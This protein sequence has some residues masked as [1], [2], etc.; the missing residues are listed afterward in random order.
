M[1]ISRITILRLNILLALTEG[2][3]VF[4]HYVRIASEKQAALLWGYSALRL[5]VLASIGL[6]LLFLLYC[7]FYVTKNRAWKYRIEENL[8]IIIGK[9][10]VF[11][12]L[13]L[14]ICLVYLVL[15][16]SDHQLGPLA[17]YRETSRSLLVWL[18][19]VSFQLFVSYIVV[20]GYDA[21]ALQ[22]HR[23]LLIP[24]GIALVFL[25]GTTGFI[26]MTKIGLTPDKLYWQDAGVPILIMQVFLAAIL[27]TIF[28]F[29]QIRWW[30]TVNRKSDFLIILSLWSLATVLWLSQPLRPAYNL[31][32][33][34]PPNFQNYPFGDALRYDLTAQEFML[35]QPMPADF[36]V[37]PFYSFLLVIFHLIAGQDFNG[38]IVVQ[39]VL[40]ACIPPLIYLFTK[41]LGTPLAGII[42]G[43]LIIF[44]ESN[45]IL[46]T[47]VIEVSHSRLLLSDVPTMG[48]MILLALLIVN[49][50]KQPILHKWAPFTIGGVLGLLILARGNPILLIPFI[51]FAVFLVIRKMKV[52]WMAFVISFGLGLLLIL[53]PWFWHNYQVTGRLIFQDLSSSSFV[54]DQ[55]VQ[56]YAG[57]VVNDQPGIIRYIFTDPITTIQFT[58][59]HFFHNVVHSYIFLPQSFFIE[60]VIGY[61]RRMP[62]WSG[63][64][65]G[66]LPD[67]RI[68]LPF[69][70]IVLA[71]G[72]GTGW[73][74]NRYIILVPLLLGIG[75]N[76]SV[77]IT[78]RS[79]WRF[80][81]PADWITIVFYAIGLGQ[82]ILAVYS[83]VTKNVDFYNRE[84][85]L[86]KNQFNSSA[87]RMQF[88]LSAFLI[89][90]VSLGVTQG[91][92]LFTNRFVEANEQDLMIK[93]ET[94]IPTL[95]QEF[96]EED[97]AVMLQGRGI[98][99]IYFKADDGVL[100]YSY[101]NY[102]AKPYNRL[103]FYLVNSQ[104]VGVLLKT[105]SILLGFQDGED[106]V[107]VGCKTSDGYI[108]A[109]AILIGEEQPSLVMREPFLKVH[110]PN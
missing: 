87:K 84:Q 44:R 2:V 12:S 63:W 26:A 92:R 39:V 56:L 60:T 35:G 27:G 31:L 83:L 40:L 98:Y 97:N 67:A 1:Q 32:A 16:L 65:G 3:L 86:Q 76:L 107:V 13:F 25:L 109:L 4:W 42:A 55:L 8:E 43:L 29:L 52:T 96:L 61:A 78:R 82:L 20:L 46:L 6:T 28:Y 11:W 74:K 69:H 103:V 77:A 45:A 37:K 49:W 71:L 51:I 75:Y 59:A 106:V 23:H 48:L 68:L 34:A 99:P 89:G 33:Q 100:N 72:F 108:D 66:L 19:L 53:I 104:S 93:Y 80:N 81:L 30:G 95:S 47:N 64:G 24:S 90:F 41:E 17:S 21:D 18:G 62:F 94:L 110:C 10:L 22:G 15:Y 88:W 9:R 101:L 5:G 7:F 79:G 73:R 58:A 102:S 38:I 54:L 14:L 105:D 91:H 36:F 85:D 57:A 70:L 50:L